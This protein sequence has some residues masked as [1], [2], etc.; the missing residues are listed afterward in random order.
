MKLSRPLVVLDLETTGTW[1]EKD[2]IVEVGMI[3]IM[4]DGT[5]E[6]YIKRVNPGMPIPA[7]VTKIINITNED[8]K[9]APRFK[10]IAREVSAFI[11][12]SDLGGFNVL[13]FDIPLLERELYEAGVNFNWRS[14]AVYDAQKVYHVHEKRDL[15]AAYLLYCGKKLEN[16]HSA[17][18][19]ADATVDILDAQIER[20]GNKDKGIESLRDIDYETKSD[21]FDKERKFCWWN[22]QLYPMFGK[23]G[24]KKHIKSIAK[25]D[26]EYLEWMLTKDFGE[27]VRVMIKKA[28]AGE[29]P[30]PPK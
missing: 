19:D 20:Y 30:E 21:Y 11:G 4:P 2:R 10:D 8:V 12:D 5:R 13:R 16:A 15:M 23:H 29:F 7:N 14:R 18:N 22:G 26:R 24:R 6:T 17:L 9:D 27:D 1:V 25:E 28:L 3:K